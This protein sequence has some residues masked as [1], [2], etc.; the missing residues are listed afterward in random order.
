[1]CNFAPVVAKP[2]PPP[3]LLVELMKLCLYWKWNGSLPTAP[4][5]A[6][7][8]ISEISEMLILVGIDCNKWLNNVSIAV[9]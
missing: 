9:E 3:S 2:P 8:L 5:T 6:T 1:M 4:A 7:M